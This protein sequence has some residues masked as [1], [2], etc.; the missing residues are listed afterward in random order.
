MNVAHGDMAILARV[1]DLPQSGFD[2]VLAWMLDFRKRL[3]VP[4]TLAELGVEESRAA[5]RRDRAERPDARERHRV[6]RAGEDH[7]AFDFVR[8]FP[9]VAA[10]RMGAQA[11]F[12]GG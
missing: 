10:P 7:G 12:T 8:Q 5:D 11:G 1:L 2:G 6:E 9:H 3:G 4:H